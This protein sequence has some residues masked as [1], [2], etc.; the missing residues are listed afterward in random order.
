MLLQHE[1][2]GRALS[3]VVALST[4]LPDAAPAPKPGSCFSRPAAS[5][6]LRP[7]HAGV[8]TRAGDDA[9]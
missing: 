2:R 4:N 1:D 9:R 6:R 5:A 7:V 3:E 8:T